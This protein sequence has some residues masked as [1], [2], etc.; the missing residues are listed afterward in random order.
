MSEEEYRYPHSVKSL[1]VLRRSLSADAAL[2]P[3]NELSAQ[4]ST[5]AAES[6]SPS[7][8]ADEMACKLIEG[9][10]IEAL[11]EIFDP[12]I[13]VNIYELGLIY[14]IQVGPDRKVHIKMTLTAPACPVAG[15]L[16]GEVEKKVEAIA[17]VTSADVELVWEPPWSRD[18]MSETALLTLGML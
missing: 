17:E 13:P 3:P 14:D 12:E 9:K 2:D 5:S 8:P 15:S 1:P 16:P 6:S 11:H 7:A 10:V 4:A 18:R